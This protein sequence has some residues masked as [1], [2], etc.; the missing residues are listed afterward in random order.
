[1]DSVHTQII[2]KIAEETGAPRFVHGMHPSDEWLVR[3]RTEIASKLKHLPPD[4]AYSLTGP[5]PLT[6]DPETN[7]KM[8]QALDRAASKHRSKLVGAGY[9]IPAAGAGAVLGHLLS[10]GDP[11]LT[12]AAAALAG[13]GV[14]YMAHRGEK[15]K[16]EDIARRLDQV[17]G[18]YQGA[19]ED[20]RERQEAARQQQMAI[21][22]ARMIRQQELQRA[23]QAGMRRG[24]R[25][26]PKAAALGAS[27]VAESTEAFDASKERDLEQDDSSGSGMASTLDIQTDDR[28]ASADIGELISKQLLV[29][30]VAAA[31]GSTGNQMAPTGAAETKL[32]TKSLMGQPP[33]QTAPP[34]AATGVRTPTRPPAVNKLPG[35]MK[36]GM[37]SSA[38]SPPEPRLPSFSGGSGATA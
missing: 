34:T 26:Y 17:R 33:T 31:L 22:R 11:A 1:M 38:S 5:V 36:D 28:L 19:V 9:G 24:G 27:A 13:G 25:G 7:I 20:A 30:K 21:R 32:D 6:T 2:N 4:V 23:Y 16:Q 14:G 29:R 8:R 12:A 10:G 3:K 18:Q 37:S 15:K 35:K